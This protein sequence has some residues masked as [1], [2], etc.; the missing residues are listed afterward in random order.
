MKLDFIGLYD[1]LTV[2]FVYFT[3]IIDCS[4][5][6]GLASHFATMATGLPKEEIR[7]TSYMFLNKYSVLDNDM[8]DLSSTSPITA[9]TAMY[10]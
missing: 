8:S 6:P 9:A 3:N 1:L 7:N 5:K 2:G 4:S 10:A